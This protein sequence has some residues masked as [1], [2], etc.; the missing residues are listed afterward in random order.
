MNS[1]KLITQ[2]FESARA[3]R[4]S[5]RLER[6]LKSSREEMAQGWGVK[7]I[8]LKTELDIHDLTTLPR[9][10]GQCFGAIISAV[11]AGISLINGIA[12]RAQCAPFISCTRTVYGIILSDGR[13][14]ARRTTSLV[15][16][17]AVEYINWLGYHARN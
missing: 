16:D 10:Q 3:E 1:R 13:I 2:L 8:P 17:S 11:P 15:F 12:F 9:L 7:F 5:I 4:E 14:L 6:L